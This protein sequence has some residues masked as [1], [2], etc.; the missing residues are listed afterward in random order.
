MAGDGHPTTGERPTYL[1]GTGKI[2]WVY[3]FR[4]KQN[5]PMPPF[6]EIK[7][8]RDSTV[9][10]DMVNFIVERLKCFKVDETFADQVGE[11]LIAGAVTDTT[12]LGTLNEFLMMFSSV[13][14][15]PNFDRVMRH[16]SQY[17]K[18]YLPMWN[19]KSSH[20]LIEYDGEDFD[21]AKT[22]M[23]GDSQYALFEAARITREFSPG[24]TINKVLLN[25]II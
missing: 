11:F 10:A 14:V 20:L 19:G 2:D 13:Q 24:H 6:E 4:G 15:A 17:M 18:N 3:N 7:F 1:S 25:V 5:Y 8:Y 12:N 22:T 16:S 23:E 9:T 21:F